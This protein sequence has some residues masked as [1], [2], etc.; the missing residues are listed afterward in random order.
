M[1]ISIHTPAKGVTVFWTNAKIYTVFISIHTPAKGVTKPEESKLKKNIYFNP[2]SREGSDLTTFKGVRMWQNFN[3]H[4]R[5]G[6]DSGKHNTR[7]TRSQISIHTP[8][9]GV[10]LRITRKRSDKNFNPHSREGSDG[11]WNEYGAQIMISIH[12]PAK[13]VTCI[14]FV[15]LYNK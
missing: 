15:Y 9:K 12:T 8:A 11:F 5:E 6:S 2:H 10:T 13:G 7:N 14:I 3:P 4:S 1:R